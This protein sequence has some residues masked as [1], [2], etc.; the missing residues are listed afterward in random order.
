[1][2]KCWVGPKFKMTIDTGA[3]TN[4]IDRKTFQK[5]KN[6]TLRNTDTQAYAYNNATLVDFLVKFEALI[7]SKRRYTYCRRILCC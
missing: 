5:L 2:L 3:T 6:L 1:M 7:E 4:V